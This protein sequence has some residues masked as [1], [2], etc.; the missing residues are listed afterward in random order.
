MNS[1]NNDNDDNNQNS[2]T[3]SKRRKLSDLPLL[4]NKA[5]EEM[6]TKINYFK[7]M[8][9]QVRSNAQDIESPIRTLLEENCTYG[10]ITS[11]VNRGRISIIKLNQKQN[12]PI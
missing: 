10:E 2:D 8:P 3:T 4:T 11:T 1:V 5:K 12:K 9:P 6:A 7:T